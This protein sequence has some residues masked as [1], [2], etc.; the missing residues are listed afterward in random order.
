MRLQDPDYTRIVLVTLPET[1]PV[2]EAA[3]LQEDLKRARIEPFAWVVNRSLAT[4][5]TTSP[6][7]AARIAGEMQQVRRVASSLAQ[8]TFVV[9]WRQEPPVG[10]QALGQLDEKPAS[11]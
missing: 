6:V 5:G 3:A 11:A 1:T 10:I 2:S 9:P 4:S 8:R 7:L